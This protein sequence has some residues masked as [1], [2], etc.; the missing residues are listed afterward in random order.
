[1]KFTWN[2]EEGKLMNDHK[3][4]T[5]EKN[6]IYTAEITTTVEEKLD[7]LC[8]YGKKPIASVLALASKC[9][10]FKAQFLN[11]KHFICD[12]ESAFA[13]WLDENDPAGIVYHR[14]LDGRRILGRTKFPP[15]RFIDA[16]NVPIP[17]CRCTHKN[18]ITEA[19]HQL[20][21]DLERQEK[22]YD[23]K[24]NEYNELQNRLNQLVV[25]YR[26]QYLGK[27]IKRANNI[28]WVYKDNNKRKA[29]IEELN[30][31]ISR[32]EKL[33]SLSRELIDA[34]P[35]FS[36][37]H[38]AE[39]TESVVNNT[40]QTDDEHSNDKNKNK[41]NENVIPD[42]IM[43]DFFVGNVIIKI[44]SQYQLNILKQELIRYISNFSPVLPSALEEIE[45]KYRAQF[46]YIFMVRDH[47]ESISEYGIKFGLQMDCGCKANKVIDFKDIVAENTSVE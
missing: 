10:D 2:I 30:L 22:V 31:L 34:A 3:R 7:F 1:M 29:T 21:K 42:N 38:K 17:G 40:G 8:E 26:S 6:P 32:Y 16:L 18:Y 13:A 43:M 25:R 24:H 20:L 14:N 39:E 47:V 5:K 37:E 46:P 15:Y 33:E 35:I 27:N 44:H 28:F 41:D 19:F 12:M 4:F 9:E 23:K 45:W 11:G 36:Y